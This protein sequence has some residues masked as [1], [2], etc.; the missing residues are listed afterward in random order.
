MASGA[1]TAAIAVILC[2]AA[3]AAILLY[4]P[5]W[6]ASD[7]LPDAFS[8]QRAMAHVEALSPAP[9]PYGSPAHAAAKAY[10]RAQIRALGREPFELEAPPRA[11][12]P[13]GPPIENITVRIPGEAATG[14]VLLVAH[15]DSR[16][17]SPGAAD[18]GAGVATLL[19][20][21]RAVQAGARLRN[22]IIFLFTDGEESGL[23]G[24][25]A[26]LAGS[27]WNPDDS[28]HPWKND[29]RIVL[30][31]DGRGNAGVV[32][33]TGA[34]PE[35]G[36]LI[37]QFAEGAPI[38]I[39]NSLMG[40]VE[41]RMPYRSDI[42][43]FREA[44]FAALNFAFADG[45]G[46]Y[47]SPLD[48]P[49]GLDSRT[50]QHLGAYA[51]PLARQFG[52]ADLSEPMAGRRVYF[53]PAGWLF[54]HYPAWLNWPL[55]LACVAAFGG[56][57]YAG[58]RHGHVTPLGILCGALAVT[59]ALCAI[60][61][62]AYGASAGTNAALGD[63][64]VWVLNEIMGFQAALALCLFCSALALAR[65][66]LRAQDL[67]LGALG[68]WLLAGLAVTAVAPGGAPL[69]VWP[70]FTL[71]AA[72][73]YHVVTDDYEEAGTGAVLLF[74]VAGAFAIFAFVPNLLALNLAVAPSQA[75]VAALPAICAVFA[76]GLLILPLCITLDAYK[77]AVPVFFLVW[78]NGFCI[79]VLALAEPR[80][81][82]AQR[83]ADAWAQINGTQEE[84][85]QAD[86]D[87][88]A[89]IR[90]GLRRGAY[91][92]ALE[93][94][95]GL[96]PDEAVEILRR[97]GEDALAHD[98]SPTAYA[99]AMTEAIRLAADHAELRTAAIAMAQDLSARFQPFSESSEPPAGL[100]ILG[101]AAA[102]R[103]VEWAGNP[104]DG[105]AAR[106]LAAQYALA[107]GDPADAIALLDEETGARAEAWAALA[108]ALD[109]VNPT[110][111]REALLA[112]AEDP[113][114]GAEPAAAEFVRAV[115][116]LIPA[117][118]TT[119]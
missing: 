91:F 21:M 9:R 87:I 90:D 17:G 116:A 31:F 86:Q 42:V 103:R 40:D 37:R 95:Y 11:F 85:H 107:A 80:A 18:D 32:M 56:T 43:P 50:L 53:N 72:M 84:R 65:F 19:E 83:Q 38:P 24:A 48:V 61:A 114:F 104:E 74:A 113:A 3:V 97:A 34:G 47:H 8:T 57:V 119:P 39:A 28:G 79:A 67:A 76:A 71:L 93:P 100:A 6:P 35:N 29:V 54:I 1:L 16:S 110:A 51:L 2:L 30:N 63:R 68:L 66:W 55:L 82:A 112:R 20:T 109:S 115:E 46:R 22:D 25:E 73:A 101:R 111:Q 117:P 99:V 69:V 58:I 52:M 5:P 96:S 14:A 78:A 59:I 45:Y 62:A 102:N 88:A 15:Y 75:A 49:A 36:W 105:T 70:A 106:L 108:Q 118:P 94:A 92:D 64:H 4:R 13:A 60:G 12:G 27:P 81:A 10:I 33:M 98:G 23:R 26:F 41:G 44:G 7:T 89:E 77:W